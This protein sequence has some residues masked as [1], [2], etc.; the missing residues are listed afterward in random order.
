MDRWFPGHIPNQPACRRIRAQRAGFIFLSKA[1]R[2]AVIPLVSAPRMMVLKMYGRS[3][4]NEL[5]IK[6]LQI[7]SQAKNRKRTWQ[8]TGTTKRPE[9]KRWSEKR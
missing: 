1:F 6:S 3:C 9:E 5:T 2:K 4:W 8:K 7:K